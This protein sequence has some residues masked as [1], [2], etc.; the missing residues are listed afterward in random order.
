ML[1][2]LVAYP[3]WGKK[4]EEWLSRLQHSEYRLI[5]DSGAFTAWNTGKTITLDGYCSFLDSIERFRPFNAVQLDVFG[6]PE[7]SYK[8]LL[9]MKSRGYDVMPVFTR[10]ESLER[11]ETFYEM[12]DYIM[13]G[14]IVVGGQNREYVKWFL[15]KNKGRKTHWLGFVNA[16]FII[17]Y[18]PESVDSSSWMSALRFGSAML[19]NDAGKPT[20]VKR[21]DFQGRHKPNLAE[22][23]ISL[24]FSYEDFRNLANP[25]AWK[26]NSSNPTQCPIKTLAGKVSTSSYIKFASYIEKHFKT[27]VY[28]AATEPTVPLLI[29]SYQHL[30]EKNVL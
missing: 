15:N 6:D 25:L 29:H 30:R 17:K 12:T 16:P 8:N 7:A 20:R 4:T 2:V 13:F 19:F 10:G 26:N 14:G 21:S 24:G 11:L 23:I 28:L 27:K 1:N 22:S 3:Y 9:T 5:I 18:Q